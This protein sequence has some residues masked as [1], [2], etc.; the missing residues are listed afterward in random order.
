MLFDRFGK[1]SPSETMMLKIVAPIAASR[2]LAAIPTMNAN[3]THHQNDGLEA[4]PSNF[5]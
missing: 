1:I 5:A 2:M 4:L 3:S